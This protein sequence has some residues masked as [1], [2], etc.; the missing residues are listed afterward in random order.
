MSKN[1]SLVLVIA[2]VIGLA[3]RSYFDEQE[4]VAAASTAQAS[5]TFTGKEGQTVE[6]FDTNDQRT[7]I[8]YFGFTR[9]ADVCPTSLAMLA[10]ALNQID[11]KTIAQL[12]PV[13]ISIDPE[14]DDAQLASTYAAYFHPKMEGLSGTPEVT[15]QVADQYGVIYRKAEL[16][17]SAMKY[18]IDHS[19]Y[20]YFV[21]PDGSL[22]TKVPHTLNP[23][24]IVE[25]IKQLTKE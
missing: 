5:A 1:W 4:K 3:A 17:D 15:Q 9:C 16:K 12:R 25:A 7:R 14:R 21:K 10:G 13:F 23:A 6:L 24:P 22:I 2:F 18:T 20:F 11:D 19:S 8:I